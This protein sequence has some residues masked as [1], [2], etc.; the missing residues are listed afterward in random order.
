MKIL[1]HVHAEAQRLKTSVGFLGD[2]FDRVYN[3]G[4]LPVDILNT[5]MR[6]F[7]EEWHV[8]MI[9]IPGNH[10][11]FDASETEHGLSPFEYAS[12]HIRILDE[13]TMIGRQLWVPWRRDTATLKRIIDLHADCDVIFGHFDIIGFKLNA[14]RISSEGLSPSIFPDGVPV[15]TGH[16]HTPQV[17]GSIR[18]LGSPYQLTL[19]EAEDEKSLLVL[20]DHWHVSD[21]IPL[22]IGR[23]QYK[24]TAN[25]LLARADI[26]RPDDRVSIACSLT[27]TSVSNILA[28]LKDRGVHVQIRRL[29]TETQTRVEKQKDMS[30]VEL[31]HAYAERSQIDTSSKPWQRILEWVKE[32][33]EQDKALVANAVVPMKIEI[34]GLGPFK[35]PVTLSMQGDGFTL[36]SGECNDT[37]GSSNGA[38]KSMVTAGAWLWAC[39]GQIDGRGPLTFD[40]ETSVIH[41]GCETASVSVSGLLEGAPWKIMRSLTLQ[42][43]HRKH[44]LRLFVNHIERTRSTL[45]GTQRAIASELFGLDVSGSGLHQ[46]LLRNSV[47]SQQSVSRWLDANDTQAKQEIHTLANMEIWESLSSWCRQLVK[48]TKAELVLTAQTKKSAKIAM[49]AAI[50]R[51][52]KALAAA[53]TW[54]NSQRQRCEALESEIESVRRTFAETAEQ[55]TIVIDPEKVRELADQQVQLEDMRTCLAKMMARFEQLQ[56]SIPPEWLKKDIEKEEALFRQQQPPNVDDLETVKSQC[57]AEK[58]AREMQLESKRKELKDFQSKGEC[59]MCGR[60][61]DKDTTHHNHL[62]TLQ[63]QIDACRLRHKRTSEAFIDA[64]RKYI[65]GKRAAAEYQQRLNIIQQVKAHSKVTQTI[66]ETQASFRILRDRVQK[67]KDQLDRLRQKKLLYDQTRRLRDELLRAIEMSEQRLKRL[68]EVECPHDTSEDEK[69]RA[70]DAFKEQCANVDQLRK[71]FD[72]AQ[73]MQKWS[74]PRGIQTYAM[75][76]TVQRLAGVMTQWLRRFYNDTSIQMKVHFDEKE[77]LKRFIDC[78]SHAGVMSGGQWRRAQLASFMAWREMSGASIPLLILDEACTSM[79][80]D[81]IRSVQQTLRDW[82]EEDP[83]RTCFFISHEPEQHRDTSVYQHHIKILHKRGRS[84]VV[85]ESN[86]K[87]QKK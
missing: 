2:F 23:K 76:T 50:M 87:R 63:Q 66:S 42:G 18:Y 73:A 49:D 16:Y 53:E 35:G 64:R 24:W 22:D 54:Q 36:V 58:K 32:H 11:Y 19:S 40:S 85:D 65:D 80:S 81:G 60:A 39:T 70:E 6:F 14:S 28:D 74:G 10:D 21:Q 41:K 4:T 33:P 29:A 48:D 69:S 9:M 57:E 43:S 56:K 1:R 78:P 8:P 79:D 7:S 75:E 31:M 12:T 3:E 15:Y 13:P 30:P 51:Y 52:E 45:S 77:R 37:R 17:H 46:W 44:H 25:E 59:T 47:W 27:D 20:D 83:D 55:E 86:P 26:L 72:D 84:Y 71:D 68:R 38:G 82:C 61:F 5:L 67:S 62:R 34:S